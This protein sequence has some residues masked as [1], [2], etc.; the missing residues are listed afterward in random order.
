MDLRDQFAVGQGVEIDVVAG[1]GSLLR[2]RLR[3]KP[4]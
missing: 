1:Q 2:S 4:I 3:L